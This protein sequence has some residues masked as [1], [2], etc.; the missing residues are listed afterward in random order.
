LA[1]LFFLSQYVVI[2]REGGTTPGSTIFVRITQNYLSGNV[3]YGLLFIDF[4]VAFSSYFII[5]AEYDY[6]NH[7]AI[8]S[9]KGNGVRY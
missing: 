8:Y 5:G 2:I 4:I 3:A 9:N 6:D 7:D 1:F